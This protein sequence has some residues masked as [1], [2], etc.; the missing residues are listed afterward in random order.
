MQEPFLNLMRR[1]KVQVSIYLQNGI[2]LEGRIESFDQ[3]VILL[4]RYNTTQMVYK[5]AIATVVPDRPITLKD[6]VQEDKP[7]S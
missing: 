5:H 1:D 4:I 2:K 6:L 7:A 3:H